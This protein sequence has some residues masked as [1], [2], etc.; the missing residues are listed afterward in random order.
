MGHK[1]RNPVVQSFICAGVKLHKSSMF[2]NKAKLKEPSL[3]EF[4]DNLIC[5]SR[6]VYINYVSK[7]SSILY[8]MS[9]PFDF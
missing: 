3:S 8:L 4:S 5:I 6:V 7:L 1:Q 2:H 9:K